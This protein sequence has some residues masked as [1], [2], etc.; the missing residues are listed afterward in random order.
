MQSAERTSPPGL[1]RWPQWTPWRVVL[2][3]GLVAYGLATCLQYL[4][5]GSQRPLILC[6]PPALA[7]WCGQGVLRL[8]P[9]AVMPA[10]AVLAVGVLRGR[11]Q[12]LLVGLVLA[13][14]GVVFVVL[15]QSVWGWGRPVTIAIASFG[16]SAPLGVEVNGPTFGWGGS[17]ADALA[18]P[19][20]LADVALR[21]V[22]LYVLVGALVDAALLWRASRLRAQ[23]NLR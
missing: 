2:A 16:S 9:V 13:V 22:P 23:A 4:Y 18:W 20:A 12:W 21:Y 5:L 19:A 7:V 14:A 11:R 6:R 17:G 1:P 10:A 3:A 15:G 8:V